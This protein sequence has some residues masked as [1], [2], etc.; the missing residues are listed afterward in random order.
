M[1]PF[2]TI[3]VTLW[4]NGKNV[5]VKVGLAAESTSLP[6]HHRSWLGVFMQMTDTG[7]KVDYVHPDSPASNAG[8][9][10]GDIVSMING[11]NF[12]DLDE[13]TTAVQDLGPGKE[14]KMTFQREGA[15]HSATATLAEIDSAPIHWM[16]NLTEKADP[17]SGSRAIEGMLNEMRSE[18]QA[19]KADV[20]QLKAAPAK[21]D[22]S[23][24]S[25]QST[26]GVMLVV[27]RGG[28]GSAYGGG[29][30]RGGGFGAGNGGYGMG[31]FGS[32]YYS[33]YPSVVAPAYPYGAY[34]YQY[35]GRTTQ[36]YYHGSAIPYG[37][38][39]GVRIGPNFSIAW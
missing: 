6:E 26:N 21:N 31:G 23:L 25:S 34:P 17:D 14:L 10:V 15:E 39:G 29:G 7:A 18:L 9:Q 5:N 24:R 28:R 27:Q 13:F 4:R 38:R 12:K 20:E 1:T 3:D 37:Y 16:L 32:P 19:L 33:N 36:P 2:D 30:Y 22:V 8:L 35:Y 11:K